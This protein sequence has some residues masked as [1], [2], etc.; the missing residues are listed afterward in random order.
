MRTAVAA[1]H[2][3]RITKA[4]LQE[5]FSPSKVPRGTPTML[6]TVCPVTMRETDLAS[7]PGAASR[8][9]TMVAVPKKAPCGRPEMNRPAS[10]R[11]KFGAEAAIRS[12]IK[13]MIMKEMSRFFGLA[14]RP[15]TR[16]RAPKQT[17]NAYAEM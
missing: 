9:A 13:A 1:A 8:W 14:R 12:P 16:I 5:T 17:P 7:L 11:A 10:R 2:K 4:S 6:A 3:A 15:K